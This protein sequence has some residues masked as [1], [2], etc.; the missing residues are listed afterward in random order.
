MR[1]G[2]RRAAVLAIAVFFSSMASLYVPATRAA[3]LPRM[4]RVP[5]K[6]A[7]TGFAL[8][9]GVPVWSAAGTASFA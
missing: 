1:L 5:D 3:Q 2:Y 4:P 6:F 7:P 9:L 8:S